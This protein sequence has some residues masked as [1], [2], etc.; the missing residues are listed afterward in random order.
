MK[1]I[2]KTIQVIF[3]SLVIFIGLLLL[4][5][6]LPITGNLKIFVVLSGSMEP[7]IKTGSVIVAKPVNDY[8]IGDIITFGKNTRTETPTTHRIVEIVDNDGRLSFTTKG[9]ANNAADSSS[10]AKSRVLGKVFLDV[11]YMGYAVSAA[12]KPY[13]F[14]FII[15]VP[16]LMIVYG[17]AEKIWKE[18]K[19]IKAK[20]TEEIE[21]KTEE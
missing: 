2:I 14:L 7:A 9:D 19:R 1:K 16:A 3:L 6:I 18:A 13:G 11:P 12:K 4:V 5:S 17:E 15:V 21:N 20:K 10:V 8:K